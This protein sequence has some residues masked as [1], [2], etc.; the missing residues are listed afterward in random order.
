MMS[1]TYDKQ[2]QMILI[3]VYSKST[4]ALGHVSVLGGKRAVN[5]FHASTCD[6]NLFKLFTINLK[7]QF[8]F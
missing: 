2:Y 7:S 4:E 8:M 1:N 3:S 5:G 6:W